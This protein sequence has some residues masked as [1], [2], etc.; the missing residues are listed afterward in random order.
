[1]ESPQVKKK[2]Y[3]KTCIVCYDLYRKAS[4]TPIDLKVYHNIEKSL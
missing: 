1:M 4:Q 3:N 2:I